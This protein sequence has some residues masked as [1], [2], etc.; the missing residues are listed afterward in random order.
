MAG[1]M[2]QTAFLV[3][4]ILMVRKLFGVKLHAYVRYG[5]WL[6]VVLRLLIPINFM[7]SPLSML[8]AAEM[9]RLSDTAQNSTDL[10]RAEFAIQADV[11]NGRKASLENILQSVAVGMD[12]EYI[13]SMEN[14]ENSAAD[15]AEAESGNG[16]RTD[17]TLWADSA[18]LK[19]SDAGRRMDTEHVQ[20]AVT[21]AYLSGAISKILHMA[22]LAGSMFVGSVLAASHIRFRRKLYQTRTVFR[23]GQTNTTDGLN[24]PIYRVKKL[25][26]P[27][28]VG[29]FR[30]AVY[31]GANIDTESDYFRY[32][33]THEEVHYLHMDH[34]WTLV[35]AALVIVYW[36]HPFVWIAAVC[37]V[38]DGE[39]ACDYGTVRRI[40]LKER[41]AYGEMLLTLSQTD[42]NNKRYT[43]GT[44]LHPSRSE[45]KSRILQVTETNTNKAWAGILTLFLMAAAAGCA[46]TGAPEVNDGKT[47]LLVSETG[48]ATPDTA[49]NDSADLPEGEDADISGETPS[50]ADS[51]LLGYPTMIEPKPAQISENTP[52]GADGPHL[53]YAGG[54]G[55]DEG[56]RI[57]FHDYF[58]LIV[59]DL[60]KREIVRSLDLKS[61]GCDMTQGDDYCETVVS[62]D[63]HT[64]W[65]HPISKEYMYRYEAEEN[66]L[67]REQIAET[68]VKALETRELFGRYVTALDAEQSP[69]G[70]YSNYLYEEYK[71]EQ[72]L[73]NAYIYL[74]ISGNS[75]ITDYTD[76]KLMLRNLNCVWD[77]M[78]FVLFEEGVGTQ[79]YADIQSSKE[80][81]SDAEGGSYETAQGI[82]DNTGLSDRNDVAAGFPYSSPY[83]INNAV[84]IVYDKPCVYNRLSDDFGERVHPF[85]GEVRVHDGI[86]YAAAEGT[87]I[88]AAAD[89]EVYETGYSAEYGNYVVI[90][91]MNGDMTYYCH[92]QGIIAKE[93][94]QVKRGDKIATVGS[95]GRAT[96]SFLHF[97]LSRNGEFIN[98][99]KHMRAE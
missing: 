35:R 88:V 39:I 89:G 31:I 29:L 65:L 17:H 22:W 77:D 87:D 45:L 11:L 4:A 8:Q 97:A 20:S 91:H 99:Q 55:T 41:F 83:D 86:D 51:P 53:D 37:S 74:C 76:Y 82:H 14:T 70:W 95:T 66:L 28:L 38:K 71:D 34:I 9:I 3:I 52:F 44:M 1:V 36:F 49:G 13:S 47:I 75:D 15:A 5:L 79:K 33:V 7:D 27:C 90:L 60:N 24:V 50:E 92:C 62:A 68:F 6:L 30:P 84:E 81:R 72:G 73:H 61:I 12:T 18:E 46:F 64:V 40:G 78:I 98:P 94:E 85:T 54:M 93:G 69:G 80:I 42:R 96:G 59:Y 10:Q 43:F 19:K 16:R 58:G 56:S 63:G 21:E 25:D 26:T 67:Y 32:A 2:I 23:D 48:K 57:I